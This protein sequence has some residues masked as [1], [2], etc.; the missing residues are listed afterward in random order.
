[1]SITEKQ[2]V[3][4]VTKMNIVVSQVF[5]QLCEG[6]ISEASSS[7]SLVKTIPGGKEVIKYLHTNSDLSHDQEYRPIMKI[8]W[9]ELKDER[10]GSWVIIQG[11]RGIGAIRSKNGSYTAIASTGGDVQTFRNDRGGNIIDFLKGQVG[12]LRK[13]YVGPDK[14]SA[15]LLKKAR[16]KQ[17]QS[18]TAPIID[19]DSLVRKFKP[20]WLKAVRAAQA[21]IKGMVANM[22]KNDAFDKA[23]RKLNMLEELEGIASS[24][25]SGDNIDNYAP[26]VRAVGNAL[27]LAAGYHYPEQTG[28]I[29]RGRYGDNHLTSTNGEGRRLLIKDISNGDQAKLSSVLAFFKRNLI[30]G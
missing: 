13:F 3:A 20:L 12:Q 1:V 24:I 23:K 29:S 15:A 16:A 6:L 30:T 17:Q 7:L 18:P 8:Q 22:I 21:D 19:Q 5:A 14:N 11:D 9:S 26:I 4:G 28:E 27:T 25:E 10:Y 2:K